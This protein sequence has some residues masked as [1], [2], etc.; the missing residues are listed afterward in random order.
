MSNQQNIQTEGSSQVAEVIV[1]VPA[2][3][4]NRTFDYLIPA[5]L[6]EHVQ[7]GSRVI[8]SFGPRKIQ[9]YVLRLKH[10]QTDSDDSRKLKHIESVLDDVAPLTK[11]L[12]DLGHWM[13]EEYICLLITALQAMLPAVL[14]S[15]TVKVIQENKDGEVE[16]DYQV[17]DK[18]TKKKI[19]MV[20]PIQ[21][22]G[23]LVAGLEVLSLRATKQREIIQFLISHPESLPLKELLDYCG[24]TRAS[25]KSLEEAGVLQVEQQEVNRDPYQDR[26]FKRTEPLLLTPEQEKAYQSI[27]STIDQGEYKTFLMHGVTGSGK[28]E[29]YLQTISYVLN[30]GKEAIVLVPEIS[31][32]PQMVERFKGRFGDLVAVLH[33]RLSSGERYDE[34]RKIR[35]GK[36]KVAIGARSALFAPFQNLGLI[37]IDEEHES[38]YKQEESPRYHARDIAIFRGQYHLAPVI[39]GSATPTLESYARAQKEVYQLISLEQRVQGRKL[40]AVEVIDMRKELQDGNRSMFSRALY[41][42]IEDR[43]ER[44][45]QMVLFLNRRGFSTFVMCRDCGFVLQCPHCDISL[46]Y[47]KINQNHRCHYCGY[48][49]KT[50]HQCPECESE[51]IRFFGTGTQKVEEELHKH[52]PGI[53]VVRMDVDTTQKKG[54][55]ERLLQKFSQQKA[56]CLLGT[57]MIAKGLDFEK[58]TL[59]GV[60]AADSLLHLPDFRSAEKTFQLLTQVSGR[61]GR[62]ELPGEV[63]VQTYTPE[64]YSIQTAAEH[65]YLNFYEQEMRHRH[66]LGYPPYFYISL[67]T[68]VHEDLPFLVKACEQSVQWLKQHVSSNTMVLGPVAS[69]IPRIK[70]RYRY[71]CMIKY[72]DEPNLGILFN[73][74]LVK[75]EANM[76]KRNL[77]ITIDKNPQMLM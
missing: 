61:A 1:E 66:K 55:H 45:E 43:I 60:I 56:D 18:V 51:H 15:K 5:A 75:H 32:T 62:H 28:T 17:T 77:Q 8:V 21:S 20:K 4:I 42:K 70:D 31:L 29:V 76:N 74:L 3:Q 46:T 69:P 9:G 40:P 68:F 58:V 37:I 25:V 12:I 33:S 47:H 52:F 7:E 14:R 38:S 10:A 63:V 36:V 49:E 48:T 44:K 65:D 67:V 57:Q 24:T 34:W 54:S 6:S 23:E 59:V 53:K 73:Q 35:Q 71:Q 13:S 22:V 64:H 26:D 27:T 2:R 41:Q 30:E 19:A 16:V 39:L 72:R 11:E 50:I